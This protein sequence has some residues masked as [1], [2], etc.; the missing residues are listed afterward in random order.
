MF[1]TVQKSLQKEYFASNRTK[2]SQNSMNSMKKKMQK[3]AISHE[4]DDKF[5]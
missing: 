2:I 4:N 5:F 1:K 3:A